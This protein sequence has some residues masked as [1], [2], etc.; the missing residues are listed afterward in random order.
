MPALACGQRTTDTPLAQAACGGRGVPA[1]WLARISKRPT[2]HAAC[3]IVPN[4]RFWGNYRGDMTGGRPCLAA[5]HAVRHATVPARTGSPVERPEACAVKYRKIAPL[6]LL[7]S[8]LA[9]CTPAAHSGTARHSSPPSGAARPGTARIAA[10]WTAKVRAMQ[11]P[12]PTAT[13]FAFYAFTP[14]RSFEVVSLDASTGRVRWRASASPSV[15]PTGVNMQVQVVAAKSLVVWLRPG[16]SYAAGEVTVAAADEATGHLAWSFGGGTLVLESNPYMCQDSKNL[17][18]VG[19]PRPGEGTRLMMLDP[20]TGK[21]LSDRQLTMWEDLPRIGDG[22]HSDGSNL[23]HVDA[24]GSRVWSRNMFAVFNGQ[25]VS[26]GTSWSIGLKNGRYVGSIGYRQ[27]NW[28]DVPPGHRFVLDLSKQAAIA[29]FDARTGRTLWVRPR[30]MVQCGPLEFDMDHPVLCLERGTFTGVVKLEGSGIYSRDVAYHHID[31]TIQGFDLATGRPTWSW[32]AGPLKSLLDGTGGV[33]LDDVTYAFAVGGK[34]TVLN[35]DHGPVTGGS[36]RTGWCN[37][38]VVRLPAAGFQ[39]AAFRSYGYITEGWYPCQ[40]PARPAR[41]PAT[42]P[43]F[44]GA[45]VDGTFAWVGKD[46]YVRAG[47]VSG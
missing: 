9:A 14:R 11:V 6:M 7:I 3:C 41:L 47:K 46:G 12:V 20:R 37:G 19:R 23:I 2:S 22:L 21:L 15:I 45:T 24:N 35:L 39:V 42:T 4:I 28:S 1:T 43:G 38:S 44:A 29:A 13:G 31:V 8:L 32:H 34:T 17:C 16:Y 27:A 18:L 36:P 26:T 40:S 30:A 33:R 10:S 25:D 5:G